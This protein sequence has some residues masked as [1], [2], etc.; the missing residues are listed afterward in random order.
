VSIRVHGAREHNLKGLDVDVP[1]GQLVVAC[2]V[3]GS[4]KTSF[5]FD[6]LHAEGQRRYLQALGL[7]AQLQLQPP[8]VDR[9][10][11]LPPT[12]ALGQHA[13]APG[14][15]QT[16]GTL[17][18]LADSLRLLFGRAGTQHCPRCDRTVEPSSPEAITARVFEGPPDARVLIEAPVRGGL[19]VLGE[20]EAAGFSRVRYGGEVQ[21]IED[22]HGATD[23]GGPLRVVVDRIKLRAERRDRL[24]ESV[25]LAGRVG[26]GLVVVWVDGEEQRY[27]DRP[28]CPHDDLELPILEPR[29]LSPRSMAGR[30]PACEGV[31]CEVCGASGLS[32]PARSVRWRGREVGHW[33]QLPFAELGPALEVAEPTDVEAAVLEDLQR[34]LEGLT[35]LG[36]GALH[37]SSPA[38]RVSSGAL[39]RLRLA[40]TVASRLGGVLYVLDEPTAGLDP[41]A[42][43]A[44]AE[45]LRGL[46]AQGSSVLAVE[47]DLTLVSAA[48]HVLE[49]GPGAGQA[50]GELVFAGSPDALRAADTTTGRWLAG[51][52]QLP[53]PRGRGGEGV[54]VVGE[55][56]VGVGQLTALVGPSGSGKSRKLAALE[57]AVKEGQTP[58]EVAVVANRTAGRSRRSMPATYVGFWDTMRSLLAQTREAQVRGLSA[59]AFSLHAKGGRCEGCKG[60]GVEVVRLD[61]LP[62]VQIPCRV[63][64]GRRFASDVLGV[65]WKGLSA[66]ELLRA[67]ART[68]RPLLAGHPKLERA[69]GA[70]VR[71]GLGHVPLGLSTDA[72]SGGEA[73]RLALARELTRPLEGRVFL[74][75]DPTVGLHPEDARAL[76]RVFQEIVDGGATVVMATHDRRVAAVADRVVEI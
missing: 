9:I 52:E 44:V 14:P 33:R 42:S 15:L 11:G 50:G 35:A 65:R 13:R 61:A 19:D 73:R 43:A 51:R 70:L 75:D 69:L 16:A 67:D 30:C 34:R 21:R 29:L 27:V 38:Q 23:D 36:L 68:L 41:E 54:V 24:T 47:H 8:D 66:A 62:D 6:T 57:A 4:G 72:L 74:L 58:F 59:T 2:G 60:L 7:S 20:L 12:L 3:S 76:V 39:Q 53:E 64:E 10:D 48:D 5:A 17:S 55:V 31:G 49:F 26:H 56:E 45:V 25:R 32:A 46:V 37:D 22:L 63:C 28:Y 1:T 71:V 40:R 18:G